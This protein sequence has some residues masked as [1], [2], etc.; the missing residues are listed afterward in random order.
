MWTATLVIGRDGLGRSTFAGLAA[1]R[2][3]WAIRHVRSM[4]DW[5]ERRTFEAAYAVCAEAAERA[6]RFEPGTYIARGPNGQRAV[7]ELRRSDPMRGVDGSELAFEYDPK[8]L[9]VDADG[10]TVRLGRFTDGADLVMHVNRAG[11][12]V[13]QTEPPLPPEL[14]KRRYLS[15]VTLPYERIERHRKDIATLMLDY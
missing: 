5:R 10:G 15:L 3:V 12:G 2:P 6:G 8:V 4:I 9:R 11:L 1:E 7:L 14:L 13:L